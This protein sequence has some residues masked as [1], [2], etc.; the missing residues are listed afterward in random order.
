MGLAGIS[1]FISESIGI[2]T[3]KI[4]VPL[5]FAMGGITAYLFSKANP[6]HKI[7]WLYHLLQGIGMLLFAFVI[8]TLPQNL[9]DFLRYVT[10]FMMLFGFIEILFGFMVLNSGE[11]LNTSILISRFV[12]GFFNL[13]GAVLIL[14]TSV[15]DEAS[16][17][18]IAGLLILMG[19]IA[20]VMFSFRLRKI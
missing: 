2:G 13:I 19:G 20:F 7:A 4:L 5:L 1:M 14:A 15:T 11:K 10:Y 8:A 16:G 6:Q 17:L 12:A 3:A 18:L 9:A